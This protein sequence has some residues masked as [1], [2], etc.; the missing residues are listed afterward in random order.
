V[1]RLQ[2]RAANAL[3]LE[4]VDTY[5]DLPEHIKARYRERQ[6]TGGVRGV[7]DGKT[8]YLVAD[9]LESEAQAVALWMHEQGVHHGLRGLVGD[10]ARM[11]RYRKPPTAPASS[12]RPGS[13]YKYL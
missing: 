12:F 10:D 7:S 1:E 2:S 6:M 8:V 13:R 9:A 4:V 3:P 11:A 5:A